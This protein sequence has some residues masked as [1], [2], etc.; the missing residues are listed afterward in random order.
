MEPNLTSKIVE[1][2]TEDGRWPAEEREAIA[3]AIESEMARLLPSPPVL[4]PEHVARVI[5]TALHIVGK[6][7]ELPEPHNE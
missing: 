4:L 6:L 1:S 5:Q 7:A 3:A 2:L